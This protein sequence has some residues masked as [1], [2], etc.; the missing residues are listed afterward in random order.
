MQ[1]DKNSNDLIN[2]P[3]VVYE[4]AQSRMERTAKRLTVALIIAIAL[5]FASNALW[6]YAW[7]QYDYG[8][9]EETTYTQDG[10]GTNIIGNG[11]GV[12]NGADSNEEKELYPEEEE[13][14]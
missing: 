10:E 6:L 13:W 3:Y 1:D 4:S 11:N 12:R 7:C 2:I 8:Y 14:G 9:E 5:M